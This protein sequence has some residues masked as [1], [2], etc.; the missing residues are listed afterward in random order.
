MKIRDV[1]LCGP[2]FW[3]ILCFI[4][5]VIPFHFL[6]P[7]TDPSTIIL[8]SFIAVPILVIISFVTG[9]VSLFRGQKD[10]IVITILVVNIAI[11]L[12]TGYIL[13]SSKLDN[14]H[15]FEMKM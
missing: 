4:L 3:L 2:G 1:L 10:G 14:G 11:I 7:L 6:Y 12:I 13:I 9:I 8:L 5:S 15:W